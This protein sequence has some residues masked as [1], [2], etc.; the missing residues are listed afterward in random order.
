MSDSQQIRDEIAATRGDLSANVNALVDGVKPGNV[1]RRQVDKVR[2]AAG[3]A[4]DK[5][6]GAMPN[7]GSSDGTSRVGGA[8]SSVG[9]T[10]SQVGSAA[11][12]S[13]QLIKQ[14]TQGAPLAAGLIAFG[15]GWLVASLI[16]ASQREQQAAVK[17]KEAAAPMAQQVQDAAKEVAGHLQEPAQRAVE[18]VKQTAQDGVAH[19]KD[20]GTSAAAQVK[21]DAQD[22]ASTVQ[23]SRS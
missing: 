3:N 7:T 15:A 18:S 16:P 5:V 21:G 13:P 6:M 10:A 22:A 8:V 12:N 19:T 17:A 9:D 2:G 23:D 4:K 20:E 14:Q 11:A 1:A